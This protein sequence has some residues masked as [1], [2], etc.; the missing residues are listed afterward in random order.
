MLRGQSTPLKVLVY[1]YGSLGDSLV[2]IPAL[3]AVRRHFNSAEIVI[4]QNDDS[5]NLVRVSEVIPAELA[6]R[7]ISYNS[8]KKKLYNFLNLRSIL[9][10]EHFDAAVF[11]GLS[12]RSKRSIMRDRLFFRFCG[13]RRLHGFIA[14]SEE[15]LYPKEPDGHPA[16][17]D[18]EAVR[19]LK[20]L[21]IDGISYR[22]SDL[23]IPCLD[24][25]RPG[26]AKIDRW[27]EE[28][29]RKPNARL[30]SIAPGSKAQATSWPIERFIELGRR[31]IAN[32]DCE[33]IVVGGPAERE[34]GNQLIGA[35]SE[36]INAAGLFG[37]EESG[38]LL[39]NCA[40]HIGVDTG[41]MH[42]AAAAGTRCFILFGERANPGQWYP[43]GGGHLLISH[44]VD[45]AGCRVQTCPLGD[46]PCMREITVDAAW[47]AL[48]TFIDRESCETQT[49]IVWV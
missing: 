17:T 35:W 46:H 26:K 36:G 45:C 20:R 44:R 49:Q 25:N 28:N 42:L 4:L 43:L 3:R 38:S 22:D 39:S 37:I 24:L 34:K 40:M 18:H 16:L 6:D 32:R 21:E 9:R 2:A 14:L 27:L 29:R 31:L 47:Q 19:K 12:E 8:Q 11:L 7:Y 15:E 41:T 48:E 13:V 10:H 30:I 1:L 33:L 5:E 23:D